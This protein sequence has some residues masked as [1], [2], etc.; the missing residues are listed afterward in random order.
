MNDEMGRPDRAGESNRLTGR[1]CAIV[2]AAVLA[3]VL[4]NVGVVRALDVALDAIHPAAVLAF[5]NAAR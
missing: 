1:D 2:A 3:I 5:D 4:A